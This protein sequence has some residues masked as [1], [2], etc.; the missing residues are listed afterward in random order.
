[1]AISSGICFYFSNLYILNFQI[2]LQI[3]PFYFMYY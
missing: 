1:M 2:N 3:F